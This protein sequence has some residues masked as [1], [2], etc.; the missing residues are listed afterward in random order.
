[1]LIYNE[2]PQ[3]EFAKKKSSPRLRGRNHG[4]H[5]CSRWCQ[6]ACLRRLGW[7]QEYKNHKGD[8]TVYPGSGQSMPYVQQLMIHILKS[9]Q[10]RRVTTECKGKKRDLVGD[11]SV[12]ILGSPRHWWSLPPHRRGG[13]RRMGWRGSRCPSL[14]CSTLGSELEQNDEDANDL[15]G[16]VLPPLRIQPIPYIPR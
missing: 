7:T 12:L 6:S 8:T 16:I 10:N 15:F 11:L 13:R 9:T 1:M 3:H 14:G 2:R 4:K 5:C